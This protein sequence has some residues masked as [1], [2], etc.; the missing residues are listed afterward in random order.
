MNYE[1]QFAELKFADIRKE[2]NSARKLSSERIV[3]V[4]LERVVSEID[5][6]LKALE[7]GS[8]K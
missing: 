3:Q 1:K 7:E 6:T 2:V 4:E 5:L 8:F